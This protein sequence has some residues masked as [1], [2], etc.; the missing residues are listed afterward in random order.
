VGAVQL[1][2]RSEDD[3]DDELLSVAVVKHGKKV[4]TGSQTGVLSLYSWGYFS[5]CS[6]RFPGD[7][8]LECQQSL[9]DMP[10]CLAGCSQFWWFYHALLQSEAFALC[11][12]WHLTPSLPCRLLP[13]QIKGHI[14]SKATSLPS[15]LQ[16]RAS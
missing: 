8:T 11:M 4:V 9:P 12:A 7:I 14:F 16:P 15:L 5:D 13:F 1:R 2:A 10:F 3:A 6:D